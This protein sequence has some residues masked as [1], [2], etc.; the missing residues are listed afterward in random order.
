MDNPNEEESVMK[1]RDMNVDIQHVAV[2]AKT[3][4]TMEASKRSYRRPPLPRGKATKKTSEKEGNEKEA[5]EFDEEES[6]LKKRKLLERAT[7]A[8]AIAASTPGR[9][10]RRAVAGKKKQYTET[11]S[12][13]DD[14]TSSD[15]DSDYGNNKNHKSQSGLPTSGKTNKRKKGAIASRKT[16]NA[17]KVKINESS[18][19]A[20]NKF[21]T[22]ASPTVKKTRGSPAI[23]STPQGANIGLTPIK[24]SV[25]K[26]WK[27]DGV[28]WRVL[29]A[30]D[31][32]FD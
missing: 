27:N 24:D 32:D 8:I 9:P 4:E 3:M 1:S 31:Y 28:D 30:I 7:S 17:K 6:P 15:D 26:V 13:T 29:G 20:T 21:I 22:D 11:D 14:E 10:R 23:L 5:E 18:S 25:S 12:A 19:K 2:E 16:S